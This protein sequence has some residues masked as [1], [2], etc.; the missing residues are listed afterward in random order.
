MISHECGCV[1][2]TPTL[3]LKMNT[4]HKI[5]EISIIFEFILEYLYKNLK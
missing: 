1:T 5:I 2:Y 3:L 4:L